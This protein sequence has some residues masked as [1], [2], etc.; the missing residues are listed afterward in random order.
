[1]IV[2]EGAI[3][4]KL[5]G[6]SYRTIFECGTIVFTYLYNNQYEIG[7]FDFISPIFIAIIK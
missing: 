1:M 5:R 2:V 7:L 4:V 6:L 3:S